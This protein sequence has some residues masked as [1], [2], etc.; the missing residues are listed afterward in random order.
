MHVLGDYFIANEA[1]CTG[2]S[3]SPETHPEVAETEVRPCYWEGGREGGADPQAVWPWLPQSPHLPHLKGGA[4]RGGCCEARWWGGGLRRPTASAW[5]RRPEA[6]DTLTPTSHPPVRAEPLTHHP[7]LG[8]CVVPDHQHH[9]A[10]ADTE[11]KGCLAWAGGQGQP[12]GAGHSP[13]RL[14][15]G[16]CSRPVNVQVSAAAGRGPGRGGHLRTGP[17]GSCAPGPYPSLPQWQL[18]PNVP[19]WAQSWGLW[20]LSCLSCGKGLPDPSWK[21]RRQGHVLHK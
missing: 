14:G 9:R 15:I 12:G 17:Q 4:V 1:S 7:I 6:N 2:E 11:E 21:T 13:Q 18:R 10:A 8:G 19:V 3:S 20:L 16:H 5:P